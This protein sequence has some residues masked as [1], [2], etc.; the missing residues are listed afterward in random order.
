M[1]PGGEC[2]K[3]VCTAVTRPVAATRDVVVRIKSASSSADD[4]VSSASGVTPLRSSMVC[5]VINVSEDKYSLTTVQQCVIS[6][7][8]QNTDI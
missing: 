2:S 5:G 8:H 1:L 4:Y 3:I 7:N 6:T